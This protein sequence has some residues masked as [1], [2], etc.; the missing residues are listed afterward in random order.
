MKH[1]PLGYEVVDGKI[2]IN[3]EEADLI[4][5]MYA[6]Y[7]LG[8]SY[9]AAA[10]AAGL[11][12][13]HSGVKHILQNKKYL[14][15]ESYPAII[16]QETFDAAEAE[17]IRR[18]AALGRDRQKSKPAPQTKYYVNF[19]M[20]EI[21]RKYMDPVKQVEFAYGLIRNEVSG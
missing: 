13:K 21:P 11:P 1:T 12:L 17:R 8:A 4:R 10:K 14:G 15:S 6:V 19:S 7:L 20:P 18:E 2:V 16:D 3:E 5:T 9:K